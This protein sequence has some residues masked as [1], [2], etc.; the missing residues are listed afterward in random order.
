MVSVSAVDIGI[1]FVNGFFSPTKTV[2]LFHSVAQVNG[3]YS[4]TPLPLLA[5]TMIDSSW[6]SV[7]VQEAHAITSVVERWAS[8]LTRTLTL[9]NTFCGQTSQHVHELENPCVFKRCR[10][11]HFYVFLCTP[12]TSPLSQTEGGDNA[13]VTY[14]VRLFPCEGA[15]VNS[16]RI[17]T[18]EET[19]A[20]LAAQLTITPAEF[21]APPCIVPGMKGRLLARM[22]AFPSQVVV[23]VVPLPASAV[24]QICLRSACRD[25]H[26]K[27][28]L[29][30]PIIAR[31]A[32]KS[33][34]K[35]IIATQG[36]LRQTSVR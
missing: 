26:T 18:K 15:W 25:I 9:R 14:M 35:F 10:H 20:G 24:R 17:R 31:H 2:P 23:V 21:G 4:G 36:F 19:T 3:E 32:M 1:N 30:K 34:S 22:T 7:H 13:L 28:S 8:T 33:P 12:N 27:K 29:S 11:R 6:P 5:L 16:V